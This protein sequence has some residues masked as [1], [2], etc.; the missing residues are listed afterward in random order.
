M[1]GE[2]KKLHGEEFADPE[3]QIIYEKIHASKKDPFTI[4][5]LDVNTAEANYGNPP[6]WHRSMEILMSFNASY[7]LTVMD[8]SYYV[9]PMQVCVIGCGCVHSTKLIVYEENYRGYLLQVHHDFLQELI[10]DIDFHV[11]DNVLKGDVNAQAVRLFEQ[12][13]NEYRK[14]GFQFSLK[15]S[16]IFLLIL[17]LILKNQVISREQTDPMHSSAKLDAVSIAMDYI[18]RHYTEEVTIAKIADELGYSYGYLARVFRETAHLKIS[19]YI[20]KKRVES[21]VNDLLHTGLSVTEIAYK[22]GYPNPQ[23]LTDDI[24]RQYGMTP[25][26]FRNQVRNMG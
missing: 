2:R 4:L 8:R 6:H 9:E 18:D 17:D 13:V 21:A 12:L 5:D 26:Q 1:I 3:S 16:G 14:N 15:I 22:N 7:I 19:D 24:R 20:R 25:K 23:S 10:P 11:F